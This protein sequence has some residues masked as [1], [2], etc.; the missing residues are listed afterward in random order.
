ML[1]IFL[2][3]SFG[4]VID[5]AQTVAP[6]EPDSMNQPIYQEPARPWSDVE[7]ETGDITCET[8]PEKTKDANQPLLERKPA[9]PNEATMY[10]AV[11][12]AENGCPVLVRY[13]EVNNTRVA[14]AKQG[15]ADPVRPVPSD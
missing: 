8:L 15:A 10:A 14:P 7:R 9:T 5:T 13:E 6:P 2:S 11:D 4:W 12:Y 1:T 3:L